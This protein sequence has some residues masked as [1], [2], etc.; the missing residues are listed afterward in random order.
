MAVH[1]TLKS[2]LRGQAKLCTQIF[3]VNQFH[4]RSSGHMDMLVALFEAAVSKGNNNVI[5]SEFHLFNFMFF[6]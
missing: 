2:I 5:R 4:G 3:C 1:P 6:D